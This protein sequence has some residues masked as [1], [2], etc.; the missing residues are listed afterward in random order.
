MKHLIINEKLKT[1]EVTENH[2]GYLRKN[3]ISFNVNNNNSITFHVEKPSKGS[4]TLLKMDIV[5]IITE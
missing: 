1:F 5:E 4:V 3:Y 2:V